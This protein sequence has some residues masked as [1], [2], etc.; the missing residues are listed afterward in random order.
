MRTTKSPNDVARVAYATA[1]RSMPAY[2]HLKSP[3]KFSQHQL[4][5]CLVLKEF[6]KTDYRGLEQIL[7]DSSDLQEILEFRYGIPQY[8]TLHK[9][10][11]RLTKKDILVNKYIQISPTS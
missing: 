3:K 5:A 1:Q 7:K 10:A 8:T 6:Y 4:V 11:Q 2:R 9:A